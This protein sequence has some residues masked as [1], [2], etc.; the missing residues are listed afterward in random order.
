MSGIVGL[1]R[2]P[3]KAIFMNTCPRFDRLFAGGPAEE[4]GRFGVKVCALGP[5]PTQ[6][7]FSQAFRA[8]PQARI[9]LPGLG[10]REAHCAYNLR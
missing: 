6:T 2:A 4:V 3:V 1:G 5:G 8:A 10:G 7:E 9:G